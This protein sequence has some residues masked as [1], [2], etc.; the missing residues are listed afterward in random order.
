[1]EGEAAGQPFV[2]FRLECDTAHPVAEALAAGAEPDAEPVAAELDAVGVPA[3]VPATLDNAPVAST[4][5]PELTGE[6]PP[7]D[8]VVPMAAL[9]NA[10]YVLLPVEGAL[11]AP[12]MPA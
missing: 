3:P 6:G 1:M 12:T 2:T 8:E 11:M 5:T 4:P 10:A 9:L 7:E